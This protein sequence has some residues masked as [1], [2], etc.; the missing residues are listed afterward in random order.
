[1][2]SKREATKKAL[3]E[4]Y[5]AKKDYEDKLGQYYTVKWLESGQPT[6]QCAKV[7]SEKVAAELATLAENLAQKLRAMNSAGY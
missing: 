2:E 4:Y 7:V 3:L 5:R 6:V 1:M